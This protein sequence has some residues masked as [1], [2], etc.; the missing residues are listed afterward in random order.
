M[1]V[2]KLCLAEAVPCK[3]W[4]D[5]Q[6]SIAAVSESRVGSIK[7]EEL[8]VYGLQGPGEAAVP[9]TSDEKQWDANK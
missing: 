5:Q 7:E 4:N 2:T 6:G 9:R 8:M 3:G 1:A